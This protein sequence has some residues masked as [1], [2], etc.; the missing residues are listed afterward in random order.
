M[1]ENTVDTKT[2]LS[3]DSLPVQRTQIQIHI[4]EQQ[5]SQ[6]NTAASNTLN[7]RDVFERN[8]VVVHRF[9]VQVVYQHRGR[10]GSR[11]LHLGGEGRERGNLNTLHYEVGYLC[12]SEAP[13]LVMFRFSS[14]LV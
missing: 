8:E 3:T 14:K 4:F 1:I 9:E 7:N 2:N 11:V 5:T 6:L 12:I 13:V 10:Q